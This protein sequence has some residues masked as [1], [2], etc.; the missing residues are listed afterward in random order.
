MPLVV[1]SLAGMSVCAACSERLIGLWISTASLARPASHPF[2]E[3]L[4]RLFDACG[5][6]EF[7]EGVCLQG[8]FAEQRDSNG[9]A[10]F[11]PLPHIKGIPVAP[12]VSPQE[13]K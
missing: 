9:N 7:V 11:T 12:S 3:R 4:N 5:F 6:D 1:T 10:V 8:A 2:Y 13:A